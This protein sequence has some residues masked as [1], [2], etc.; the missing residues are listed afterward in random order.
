[1]IVRNLEGARVLVVEDDYFLATD[2]QTA[3]E[4]AGATVVGPFGDASEAERAL[5]A[6]RPDCAFVDVNLGHGPS[7]DLPRALAREDVPFAFVTGYDPGI[8]PD[9]FAGVTRFEKP[10]SATKVVQA[11]AHMLRGE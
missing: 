4:A 9:E 10:M 11:M 1:M 2:L 8:I 3:L 7:F 6:A 5:L